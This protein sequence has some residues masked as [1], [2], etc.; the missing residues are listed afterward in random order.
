MLVMIKALVLARGSGASEIG[1]DHFL[2][3]LEPE[4]S[5]VDPAAP[6]EGTFFPVPRQDIALSHGAAAAIA[7]L[8]DISTIPLDVL[9]S[10]LL[11]AKRQG[12]H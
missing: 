4:S 9:R 1:I 5:S 6:P 8:G 7:T 10:A 12:A 11:S 2:A 3:A